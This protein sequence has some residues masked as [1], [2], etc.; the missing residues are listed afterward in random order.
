MSKKINL[1]LIADFYNKRFDKVGANI[2]SVGWKNHEEQSLRFD[3]LFRGIELNNK[4][5][6]DVGCGLG[7]LVPYLKNRL[8]NNFNYIGIDISKNLIM[9][10]K[11]KY[12]YSNVEFIHGDI[13]SVNFSKLPSIDVSIA[14][15]AFSFKTKGLEEYTSNALNKMFKISKFCCSSNF[16][17]KNVDF[18]LSKNQH[19]FPDKTLLKAY[20]ISN[21]VNLINDYPLY[22]FTI[23][24]FK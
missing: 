20:Q 8:N 13:N 6:L 23:Q 12:N 5:I 10:A 9:H 19:Y 3:I 18:E 22:E 2:E 15:G 1:D 21:K 24:I 7:D 16:L 4:T 14:S 11:E 17:T